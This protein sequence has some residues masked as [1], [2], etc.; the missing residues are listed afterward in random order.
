MHRSQSWRRALKLQISWGAQSWFTQAA[1]TIQII[2][3]RWVA[4][5]CALLV[6]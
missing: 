3:R 6:A 1:T 5:E 2:L 4:E